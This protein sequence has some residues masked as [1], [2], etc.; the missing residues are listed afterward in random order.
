M[1]F[2]EGLCRR[3][4]ACWA[5]C[6]IC[7]CYQRGSVFSAILELSFHLH[8]SFSATFLELGWNFLIWKLLALPPYSPIHQSSAQNCHYH[9]LLTS[10]PL[11][12]FL[13]RLNHS[14]APLL[15]H[16][17]QVTPARW[18][19]SESHRGNAEQCELS[20]YWMRRRMV[21]WAEGLFDCHQ[22]Q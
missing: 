1:L 15:A 17:I 8:S 16:L 2:S 12:C 5:L 10:S 19:W 14:T 3:L 21:V 13:H 9:C 7:T 22:Q 11:P 18:N 4:L 6:L 20:S